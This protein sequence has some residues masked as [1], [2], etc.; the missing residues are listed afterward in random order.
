V[1]PWRLIAAALLGAGGVVLVLLTMAKMRDRSGTTNGQ[2]ALAGAITL[3]VLVLLCVLV[4]TVL[5]PWLAWTLV[6]TV[7]V[8]VSVLMLA[9]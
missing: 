7:G 2:V 8:T 4:L 1:D 6:V 9:S 3:T 5:V